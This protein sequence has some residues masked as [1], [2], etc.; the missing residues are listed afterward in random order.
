MGGRVM[1]KP[2]LIIGIRRDRPP[3]LITLGILSRYNRKSYG[4]KFTRFKK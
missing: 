4:S 1:A 2:S 3:E